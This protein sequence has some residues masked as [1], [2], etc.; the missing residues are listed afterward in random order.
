MGVGHLSASPA[1]PVLQDPLHAQLPAASHHTLFACPKSSWH[2]GLGVPHHG[3]PPP[4]GTAGGSHHVPGGRTTAVQGAGTSFVCT[5]GGFPYGF[6]SLNS[7]RQ[8]SPH[9]ANPPGRGRSH[10]VGCSAPSQR[11]HCA[12]GPH[13]SWPPA[14]VAVTGTRASSVWMEM[15][16]SSD[17]GS[18]RVED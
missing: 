4:F 9:A 15:P 5:R 12:Q 3:C 18:E 17:V 10:G 16:A 1:S 11:P 2:P 8:M 13:T 14:S 6:C 7:S